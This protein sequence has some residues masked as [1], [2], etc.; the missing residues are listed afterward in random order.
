MKKTFV[1]FKLFLVFLIILYQENFSQTNSSGIVINE[2]LANEPKSYTKLEWVELYNLNS[3]DFDLG[4]FKFVSKS[5]TT[6]FPSGTIIPGK[7]YLVLA[8]KLVTSPP[9]SVSF[10]GFWGDNT[11]VW[12]DSEIEDFLTVEIKLSLTNSTGVVTLIDPENNT[13]S[14]TWNKDCGDGISWEK[15]YPDS[16]DGLDNWTACIYDIGSTPGR[17]NS[18]TPAE[19]DLSIKSDDLFISPENPKEDQLF[20]LNALVR[21]VGTQRS[22]ANT[23]TFYSDYNF[24]GELTTDEMISLP[25]D[26]FPLAPE[27]SLLFFS[28]LMFSKGSYRFYAEIGEDDKVYNNL[29]FIN[30][31]ISGEIPEVVINEFLPNPQSDGAEWV[32]LFNRTDS[33]I[34]IKNWLLGDSIKQDIITEDE[35]LIEPYNYLII[36]EDLNKFQF[37][38]PQTECSIIEQKGW[39][40]LNNTGD[41][42]ILKDSLGFI[43]DQVSYTKSWDNGVSWERVDYDKSSDDEDNWW[44]CVYGEGATPCNKNSISLKY[45]D[46]VNLAISPDP[47]SPDGDGFE[48]SAIF[49][50][51]IPLK[52]EI[53]IK[54]YDVKGRLVKTLVEEQPLASGTIFWD[55]KDDKNRKVRAGI[56][57]VFVEVQNEKKSFLKTTVVVAKK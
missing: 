50:Y 52:S 41:K 5:D 54:I 6:E 3:Y 53:S 37:C 8:R 4:G 55:G 11:G 16:G 9:D 28:D 1:F 24:D 33:S 13:C 36:T 25:Q 51:S 48:D 49:D 34:F 7:G 22:E 2:V 17:L 46:D 45:T 10:E 21:N 35:F 42:I 39:S 20:R 23:I 15:I 19:N 47:F 14:F 32:E 56:Y 38:F 18:V 26:I 57:V 44:R 43:M 29:A 40:T 31:K 27:D 30:V 12:G